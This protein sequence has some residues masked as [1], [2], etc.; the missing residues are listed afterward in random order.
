MYCGSSKRRHRKRW[1][2]AGQRAFAD[3]KS[4]SAQHPVK[5]R[6]VASTVKKNL[7]NRQALVDSIDRRGGEVRTSA[8]ESLILR[9]RLARDAQSLFVWEVMVGER[10]VSSLD[11]S[12]CEPNR[13][14]LPQRGVIKPRP[15][16]WAPCLLLLLSA[17]VGARGAWREGAPRSAMGFVLGS[18]MGLP[19]GGERGRVR[20]NGGIQGA[21]CCTSRPVDSQQEDA[22]TSQTPAEIEVKRL[23]KKGRRIGVKE[24]CPDPLLRHQA[25]VAGTPTTCFPTS[26]GGTG[27]RIS[28]LGIVQWMPLPYSDFKFSSSTVQL[29]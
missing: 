5:K 20:G 14:L 18:G 11:C 15:A 16:L 10:R 8:S 26:F 17:L 22:K 27:R 13:V 3:L 25:I 29:C 24:S 21:A 23:W 12:K 7:G 1:G 9:N 28:R 4:F 2:S 6:A 19:R